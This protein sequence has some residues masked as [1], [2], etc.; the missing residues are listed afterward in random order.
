MRQKIQFL[1]FSI[2]YTINIG[3]SNLSLQL[4][5]IPVSIS[6]IPSIDYIERLKSTSCAIV[7]SSS[8]GSHSHI[9]P[10]YR[11]CTS[12]HQTVVM[13]Y[14]LTCARRHWR[15]PRHVR[16]LRFHLLGFTAHAPWHLSRGNKDGRHE[17][18][19]NADQ[20]LCRAGLLLLTLAIVDW[21]RSRSVVWT[22][23]REI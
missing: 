7:S 16:R 9:H 22:A 2:L 8:P 19:P 13:D 15:V 20:S 3:V 18:A 21:Q 12:R 14:P 10:H 23:G 4:V 6:V 5:S 1:A 17:Y 11:V